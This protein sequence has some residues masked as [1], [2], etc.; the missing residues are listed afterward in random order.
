MKF[1]IILLSMSLFSDVVCNDLRDPTVPFVGMSVMH[2]STNQND[3][4]MKLQA[5]IKKNGL[6]YVVISG[7]LYKKGQ[8]YNDEYMIIDITKSSVTLKNIASKEQVKL[9]LYT[10]RIKNG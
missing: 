7:K 9:S 2:G 6:L 4:D 8:V 10:A 1:F 5:I 3:Q